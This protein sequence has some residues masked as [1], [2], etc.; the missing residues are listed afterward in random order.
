MHHR[1]QK[2]GCPYHVAADG[3]ELKAAT[4]CRNA[5]FSDS[6]KLDRDGRPD[7]LGTLVVKE[8]LE[9]SEPDRALFDSSG[10]R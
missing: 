1:S 2:C 8:A 4:C 6:L 10:I 5:R 7:I 9:P 3:V